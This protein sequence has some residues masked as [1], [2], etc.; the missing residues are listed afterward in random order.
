MNDSNIKLT[1]SA[2][3]SMR[4][5]LYIFT[6]LI[7]FNFTGIYLKFFLGHDTAWGLIRMFNLDLENNIPTYFSSFLLLIVALQLYVL[8]LAK[9]KHNETF[10]WHWL[11]LSIIFLC[12]SIDEAAS[13]HEL[14]IIPLR[15]TFGLSGIFYYSW[16]IIGMGVVFFLGVTYW[17]FLCALPARTKSNFLLAA[18]IYVGGAIG[19]ELLGGYYI[20]QTITHD[21]T[22]NLITSLEEILELGGVIIFIHALFEFII[23]NKLNFQININE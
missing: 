16:V 3:K 8:S 14:L 13:I 17:R 4:L 12:L 6:A 5:I 15:N 1:V 11:S 10:A 2:S 21:L 7:L 23:S 9:N 22:Y 20:S 18:A 19:I